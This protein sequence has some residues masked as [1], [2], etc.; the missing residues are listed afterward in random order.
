[1]RVNRRLVKLRMSDQPSCAN[2]VHWNNYD[3][4]GCDLAEADTGE[5]LHFYE[6]ADKKC[7]S[8]RLRTEEEWKELKQRHSV[9]SNKQNSN[10]S[11]RDEN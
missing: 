6:D 3:L 2:C 8:Y 11:M 5:L 4:E 1:M 7:S 9:Y 10:Q